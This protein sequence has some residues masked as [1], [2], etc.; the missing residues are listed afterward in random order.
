MFL[1]GLT[2]EAAAIRLFPAP[3]ANA[4][5]VLFRHV[6]WDFDQMQSQMDTMLETWE[7]IGRPP[8]RTGH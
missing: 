2:P 6:G 7:R 1:F 5:T 3:M 8:D 4:T